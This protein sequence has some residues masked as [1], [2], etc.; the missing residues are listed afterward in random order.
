MIC[1]GCSNRFHDSSVK[2]K[3]HICVDELKIC[4]IY[5]LVGLPQSVARLSSGLHVQILVHRNIMMVGSRKSS[6]APV[7]K[8]LDHD[9]FE[10]LHLSPLWP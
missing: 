6:T 7:Y 8:K 2:C 1:G 9:V 5:T 10:V 4:T 3:A